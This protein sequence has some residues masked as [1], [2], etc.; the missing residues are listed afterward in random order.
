MFRSFFPVVLS[1][2]LILSATLA[3]AQGG[4]LLAADDPKQISQVDLAQVMASDSTHWLSVR[5]KGRARLAVVSTASLEQTKSGDAWLRA[6]DFATRER[7]AAPPGPL[8]VCPERATFPFADSGL[9][10]VPSIAAEPASTA[11]SELELQRALT[12]AGI[13]VDLARIDEFSADNA[14]PYQ[15]TWFDS[16]AAGGAS[17]ALRWA[18][19]GSLDEL[20]VIRVADRDS[21]P[22]SVIALAKAAAL[23]KAESAA[24]PSE[25]AVTYFALSASSDYVTA[26]ESWLHDNADRWLVEAASTPALFDVTVFAGEAQIPAAVSRYFSSESG[27]ACETQVTAAHSHASRVAGDFVCGEADDLAQTL[28]ELDFAAVRLTRLF[29]SSSTAGA[30]VVAPSAQQNPRLQATDFETKGCSPLTSTGQGGL[31][32]PGNGM[33]TGPGTSTGTGDSSGSYTSGSENSTQIDTS[34]DQTSV[35]SNDSGCSVSI[36]SSSNDDS[37]SGDSSTSSSSNSN[38]SC[39]GNPSSDASSTDDSCSGNSSS[40][41]STADSCTGN[42][43]SDGSSS[44]DSCT[45]NSDSSSSDSSGCGSDDKSGYNGDTCSGSSASSTSQGLSGPHSLRSRRPRR[46]HLSLLTLLAAGLSLPLRRR[47]K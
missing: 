27:S 31:V 17:A 45:G 5:L 26:R 23:P 18:A 25:F 29:G 19:H 2:T 33:G 37:C 14:S 40:D 15:I 28:G 44:A 47:V 12:N 7:I 46:V 1:S 9:P 32:T 6:L 11:D 38:D 21:V 30:F 39:S 34:V 4:V 16:P 20:P 8:A 22:V 3:R 13:Q 24:D 43:S 41:S 42:S 10:E 35:A 36:F